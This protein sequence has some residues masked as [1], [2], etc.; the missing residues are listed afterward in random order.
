[1]QEQDDI[2]KEI[3]AYYGGAMYFAQCLEKGIMNIIVL[4][5]IEKGITKTRIEELIQEKSALTFGQL[6]RELKELNIFTENELKD[7]DTFH[8]KRDFLAHSYWWERT[9][10]FYDPSLQHK[11]LF[12]LNE[13]KSSF[14]ELEKVIISKASGFIEQYGINMDATLL[15]MLSEG[16]TTPFEKFR[17]L[18]KNETVISIFGY[19]ETDSSQIPIFEFS[20]N[21]FWTISEVGLSQYK[22]DIADQK[23]FTIDKINGIMPINQFNPRPK[24]IAPWNYELDLKKRGLIMK[25]SKLDSNCQLRWSIK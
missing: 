12:E 24:I 17:K 1:M 3:F 18:S 21:T 7:I 6:K 5:T 8:E 4:K 16:A 23:K 14:E 11:L 22:S 2:L 19:N 15:T 13:Y 10:E 9:V 20:D 25:I